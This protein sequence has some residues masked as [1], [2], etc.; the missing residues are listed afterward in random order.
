MS[1]QKFLQVAADLEVAG[2]LWHPEV[3]DEVL[4]RQA[5]DN[6]SIL[7]DPQGLTPTELREAYLWLPTVE[8]MLFQCEARKAVLFHAGTELSTI[9]ICYKTIIQTPAGC[10]ESKGESFRESLG[11]ALRNLLLNIPETVIN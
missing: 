8:Q 10:F 2:L 11:I 9:S 4:D 3:G 1:V 7:V 5:R 6:V